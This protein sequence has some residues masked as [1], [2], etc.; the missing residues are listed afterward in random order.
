MKPVL[1]KQPK[2]ANKPVT[3]NVKP[4]RKFVFSFRFFRQAEY[5][6]LGDMDNGWFSALL[7]KLSE[8][9][10]AD[11]ESLSSDIR[12]KQI[13][14]LHEINFSA[15]GVITPRSSFDWVAKPY[16]ENSEEY[17][18]FQFQITKGHGRVI[19]F[20]DENG[21]FNIVA[22][23]PK[24]N[25]Q[26]SDYTDYKVR[27][28]V[29]ARTSYAAAIVTIEQQILDCGNDCRC[30]SLYSKIQVVLSAG[31]SQETML[32]SMSEHNFTRCAKCVEDGMALTIEDVL[33][34]GLNALSY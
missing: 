5:F 21:V 22:L 7:E 18:F 8:I 11:F 20:W 33:V 6:G 26:P 1:S 34:E 14:R 9:S 27:D 25:M 19:G 28:T 32:V 30:R 16:L 15:K 2:P 29:L 13:W 4:A 24:H 3:G 10:K 23:D 12:A 31:L 17:P